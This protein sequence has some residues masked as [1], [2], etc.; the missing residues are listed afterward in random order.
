MDK[1]IA[2]LMIIAEIACVYFFR[3]HIKR[4]NEQEQQKT[5][6]QK[7]IERYGFD[8]FSVSRSID[9]ASNIRKQLEILDQLQTQIDMA[10]FDLYGENKV[11]QIQ[12]Y[13]AS[14]CQYVYYDLRIGGK[15][16]PN[17]CCLEQVVAYEKKR[18]G[19]SLFGEFE[20]IRFYGEDK[21]E[22]KAGGV[23]E[24]QTVGDGQPCEER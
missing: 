6:E 15:N 22:D 16:N 3:R 18:L 2:Y 4:S 23:V 10:K 1:F 14:R 11:V 17:A 5:P 24:N 12:W 20:K 21:A 8:M 19:T 13:D 7:S 9:N